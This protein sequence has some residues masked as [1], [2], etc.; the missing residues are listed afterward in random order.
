[1]NNRKN[2]FN[3]LINLI[4]I[5]LL[6]SGFYP[7]GN[8]ETTS[9]NKIISISH[10]QS[11]TDDIFNFVENENIVES[12]ITLDSIDNYEIKDKEVNQITSTKI[13]SRIGIDATN[14][15]LIS[16][17]DG[18]RISDTTPLFDWNDQTN[19]LTYR[20]MIATDASF[21][22]I[23]TDTNRTTSSFLQTTALSDD[24]YYW[25]VGAIDQLNFWYWSGTDSFEVETVAPVF[26]VSP[27][28][29]SY[30]LG[31]TGNSIAWTV[32]DPYPDT[33]YIRVDNV[34]QDSG[35][36]TSGTSISFSVDGLSVGSHSVVL[37]AKDTSGNIGSDTA[38]V[39]VIDTVIPTITNPADITFEIGSTGNSIAWTATDLD[40]STYSITVNTVEVVAA[41]SWISGTAVSYDID[42]L[43]VGSNSVVIT[44]LDASSNSVSDSVTVTVTDT[45]A[46]LTS[47][48]A[49]ASYELG[50]TGNSIAWTA[51]DLDPD[52]YSITVDAVEVV[53]TISWSSGT[54]V[55]YDIDGLAVGSHTIIITFLDSSSNSVSDSVTVTVTDTTAPLTSSPADVSYELG[56]TGNSISWTATDLDPSTYNITI[57]SILK[58][59]S[60]WISGTAVSYNIDGLAVGS[61]IVIIT[62]LDSSS[63]S[64]SD[65]VTITVTDTTAPLTDNPADVSYELGSTGNSI[66]WT[67]TDLDPNTY[68]ITMDGVEVVST[69]SWGSG[70]AVSYS[71]D[72]LAVGSYTVIITFLDSSSNSVS[73]TVIVTVSDTTAPLTDNP[74]DVSY[75]LGSTGNSITWT[76]TDLDPDTYSITVNAVEVVSATSWSSGTA[77]SY[78]IDGL[79]VGSYTVIITFLDSSSN[80]VSDTVTITV[81]DTTA[82]LTDNPVNVSYELG[83][84]GNSISWTATDLDPSTYNITMDGVEVVSATSWSSG[85]AVSYS[86]DGLTLGS[87]TIV[88]TFL[89]SSSNSV[90][91]T[92]TITVTDATAPLTSNPADVSY[93]L[94]STGNSI[95]WTAT[96]LDPTTYTISIDS[97]LKINSAWNSGTAVSY[98]IDGLAVG[99]YTVI[100]TF[101]DSSSNSVSDTVTITVTDA[102]APLTSNPADVNYE[103]GSTGNSI[104][105]TAT[106]LDPDTYSITMDGVEVVSA[107]SWSSGTAVSYSIDGLALGSYTIVIT[108]LDASSNSVSDTVTITV[109]DTTA[110][111]T[112]NPADVSYELGSTGNSISWTATDLD[113][114]TYSITMDGI[115]VVS[116]TSWSSGTAVPYSIDGLAVG[117]YTIVIT[118]LDSSSNSVSDTVTI[119]VSDTTAPLTDNPADVSYELGST[120]NSISWTVTDFDPDTYSI[121]MDGVEVVSATSWSSGTAVSYNI[122]GLTL[123]IYVIE[124]TFT[125]M[126]GNKQTDIVIVRIN[127]NT[128]PNV[129]SPDDLSFV[130]GT[131]GNSIS[132]TATD[133]DPDTYTITVN[134]LGVVSATSWTSGSEVSFSVDYLVI[135][136]YTITITFTDGSKNSSTDSVIVTVQNSSNPTSDTE[137][138]PVPFLSMIISIFIL[139]GLVLTK[140]KE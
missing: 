2:V 23:I 6:V 112:D 71:I 98:N 120:G 79:A 32:T 132:W 64:V 140:R 114:D 28:D 31:T 110:P 41:T 124:I 26:T 44:F 85:T 81:T 47:N 12:T 34:L 60:A 20:I 63:N 77:V 25:K 99:S 52:T 127:D 104:S 53:A 37:Q 88:I 43:P 74:A 139:S 101:F 19:V 61:Y 76:A 130:A 134:G 30:E 45:T 29:I 7:M 113:P 51:T 8:Y 33:Y 126:S 119:T 54:V 56:S 133:L 27:A 21:T 11:N 9:D 131:T 102:T 123:G 42:G 117:S 94:G 129:T 16:P 137:E 13:V 116:A 83:S 93:E 103:F 3:L 70:T 128:K 18:A 73:D 106:D 58:I 24:I 100:I 108:F 95:S 38:I 125:D 1:M 82:P 89:D 135:G 96:D 49:D 35:T 109:T 62:F 107:T 10:I 91:D 87:Y 121:T 78:N 111:L 50:S 17:T 84:T 105:W 66:S 36:W 57:D 118:F 4:I 92:V 55:S 80:S 22:N 68:S 75:E 138:S 90:S 40:P 136:E 14:P 15:I 5:I 69:T 48:P 97:I 86:I 59:N 46:P 39:N 67:A 65:T 115:E 122:D 72:G